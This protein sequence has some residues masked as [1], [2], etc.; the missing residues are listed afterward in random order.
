M[1]IY[2]PDSWVV[3]R[4]VHNGE[5]L[6]KVLGGWYGGYLGNNNFRLNSG[7]VSAEQD[8][9]CWIFNGHSGSKYIC[10]KNSY[11]MSGVMAEFYNNLKKNFSDSIELMDE[12][13]DWSTISYT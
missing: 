13:T 5:T 3:I 8:E 7:I 9:H 4:I 6:Y 11:R 2:T 10:S 12:N 1:T